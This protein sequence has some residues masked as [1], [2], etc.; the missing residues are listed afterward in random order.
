MARRRSTGPRSRY[1]GIRSTDAATAE[2]DPAYACDLTALEGSLGAR[3]PE[4]GRLYY[5]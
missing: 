2:R 5:V 4:A 1:V 3:T